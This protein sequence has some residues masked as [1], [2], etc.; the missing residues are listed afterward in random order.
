MTDRHRVTGLQLLFNTII[1]VLAMMVITALTIQFLMGQFGLSLAT[2][3]A[4][5]D[6]MTK[7]MQLRLVLLIN[8]LGTWGIPALLVFLVT[9]GRSWAKAA[10]LVGPRR[11]KL[12]GNTVLVF[13]FGM[14]VVA[15]SAYL[16]LQ[17]DLPEWMIQSE[18]QGNAVL[19]NVLRFENIAELLLALVTVAV[20]PAIGEEL[21]FRGLLQGRLLNHIM[22]P[23]AAI[24]V[25]AAIFSAIHLE[26]AGF[27]PRFILGALLGYGYRWCGTLWIP[28]LLHFFFNGLQVLNTYL[29]G[30][31]TP[32]TEMDA[33]LS[34]LLLT[35]LLSLAVI[36]YLGFR[37]ET[38]Y[39]TGRARD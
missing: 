16:N 30:E 3:G 27:L 6:D 25:S 2:E 36:L 21:M 34:G 23:T 33:S 37:N 7:R 1:C 39:R 29:S 20:V 22:S 14:P 9:Y 11:S 18:V 31:F 10:G 5:L 19:A 12:I 35:G 26:F 4:A 24:W 15:L 8:N 17:I 32:D 38:S 28:I 13:V